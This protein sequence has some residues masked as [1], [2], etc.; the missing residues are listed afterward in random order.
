MVQTSFIV[1]T[2]WR[3]AKDRGKREAA[4]RSYR[5]GQLRCPLH[6]PQRRR[7][8]HLHSGP[9]QHVPRRRYGRL[10]ETGRRPGVN[11]RGGASRPFAVPSSRSR[12]QPAARKIDGGPSRRAVQDER[13][14]CRGIDRAGPAHPRPDDVPVCFIR[15]A[16]LPLPVKGQAP[17]PPR[18]VV[19]AGR[20][21]AHDRGLTRLH[22]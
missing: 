3:R 14:P 18:V 9:P 16:F 12:G 21:L 4:K 6:Q 17:R 5:L 1:F 2:R 15:H 11:G 19:Q 10:P 20:V 7:R 22:H 8:H 13:W